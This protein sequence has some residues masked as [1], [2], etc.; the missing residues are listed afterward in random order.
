MSAQPLPA[1]LIAVPREQLL[2][3]ALKLDAVVTG[4][5]GVA[6]LVLAGPLG[7]LFDLPTGFLRVIGAFLAVFAIAVWVVA[8]RA[9]P[10]TAAVVAVSV[11]WVLASVALLALEIHRPSTVGVVWT[12]VQAIMVAVFAALPAAACEAEGPDRCRS[13][14]PTTPPSS[15]S[16][17]GAMAS[18]S[19]SA[20]AGWWARRCGS[21][22]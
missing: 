3:L 17:T 21:T 1:R 15:S 19:S 12:A 13:S 20:M 22:S 8:L 7:D 4:T 9:R 16:P 5:N 11:L 10:W 14:R 2:R 6:Y 18:P